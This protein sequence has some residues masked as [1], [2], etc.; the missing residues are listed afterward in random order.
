MLP[1]GRPISK[2]PQW[3]GSKIHFLREPGRDLSFCVVSDG[4]RRPSKVYPVTN[5]LL[6]LPLPNGIR[7][8][9]FRRQVLA[10][11]RQITFSLII[12]SV[13]GNESKGKMEG[14]GAGSEASCMNSTVFA[15]GTNTTFIHRAWAEFP[16]DTGKIQSVR[17][18]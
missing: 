12:G 16:Q 13:S 7:E 5:E 8:I 14:W 4:W 11:G 2:E 6:G 17:L 15:E 1:D 3:I 10:P 9:E 18:S